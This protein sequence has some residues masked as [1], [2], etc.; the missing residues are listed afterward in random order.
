[1]TNGANLTVTHLQKIVHFGL[2]ISGGNARGAYCNGSNIIA[3]GQGGGGLI[4]IAKNV[5]FNGGV[6]LNG[7]NGALANGC[8]YNGNVPQYLFSGGGGAGSC[9][10]RT[11]NLIS[12]SGTFT[13]LGGSQGGGCPKKGG[14]G[15]M[16]IIQ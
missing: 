14:N 11:F 10:F 7:G 2:D 4:I 5:I 16:I 8:T 3:G 6:I 15:S 1:M 12:N 9:I 13:S